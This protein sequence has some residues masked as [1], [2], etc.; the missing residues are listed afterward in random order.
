MSISLR[1]NA[2]GSGTLLNG[3]TPV[4]EITAA[5]VVSLPNIAAGSSANQPV[6]F[7]QVI[8]VGQTWQD[9]T[10]SRA[11]GV[12]YTNSTGKPIIFAVTSV[13]NASGHTQSTF[14]NGV[15][16][17]AHST[18]T[19]ANLSF[20]VVPAGATYMTSVDGGATLMKWSELR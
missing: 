15:D 9:V 14:V 6:N 7:G 19:G 18:A 11:V 10:A 1:S 3:S 20:A 17:G 12:T 5:G 2:D 4:M 13:N 8:G 16:L